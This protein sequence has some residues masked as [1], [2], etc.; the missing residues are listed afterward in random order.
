MVENID[1]LINNIGGF[2][3]D[4]IWITNPHLK[5]MKPFNKIY[6]WKG[7]DEEYTSKAMWSIVLLADPRS[8]F[9]RIDLE[10]R[11][12]EIETYFFKDKLFHLV[13]IQ[14]AIEAY[15]DKCLTPLLKNFK[16]WTDLLNERGIYMKKQGYTEETWESADT[17]LK[18]SKVIWDRYL[19]IK[20]EVDKSESKAQTRGGIVK[21]AAERG[22][23]YND[24]H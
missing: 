18:N 21:S 11:K 14:K 3:S 4:N 23:L 12:K 5:Y 1:N 15:P 19:A 16:S 2:D 8:K 20:E 22:E 24:T 17:M 7:K 9:H 6:E 13:M 10:E